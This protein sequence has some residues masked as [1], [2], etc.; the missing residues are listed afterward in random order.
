MTIQEVEAHKN[1][2]SYNIDYILEK[3]FFQR[4]HWTV[5]SPVPW[6][7]TEGDEDDVEDCMDDD[8]KDW[9][10]IWH[11]VTLIYD[12]FIQSQKRR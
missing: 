5:P 6:A 10:K 8:M 3:Y 2:Q 4:N 11:I 1:N 7:E 9:E 12:Y